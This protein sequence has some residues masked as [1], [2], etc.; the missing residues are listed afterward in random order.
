MKKK[1]LLVLLSALMILSA[2]S[3]QTGTAGNGTTAGQTTVAPTTETPTTE[4]PTEEWQDP[5]KPLTETTLNVAEHTSDVFRAL[6]RTYVKDN[7]FNIDFAC[8]GIHFAA[9]CEGDVKVQINSAK[10]TRF[11]IYVDGVR[12][13]LR[14]QV[15]SSN[16]GQYFTIAKDLPRG[17][18][19]FRL[20]SQTQFI[21]TYGSI[22]NVTVKGVFLDKPADRE[23]YLE[24]Y[25]DSILNGSNVLVAGGG[26]NASDA[27]QAFGFVTAEMMNADMAL[28][29]CS[30]I[31]LTTNS[32]SF[33]MKDLVNYAGARYS[34]F[35]TSK[36]EHLL[37]G[38]PE[39]DF[40][41]VPSAIIIEQGV[42]DGNNASTQ[43]FENAVKEMVDNLRSK[44]GADVPIVFPIGYS[45]P[46]AA[47]NTALPKIVEKLGG[48]SANLYICKLSDAASKTV[49][50]GGDG[51]H[52]G[53]E[54]TKKMATEL[55]EYLK[56]ILKK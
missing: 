2:V 14:L 50:P 25:G 17:E 43:A 51:T 28:I 37:P 26:I 22:G 52:P 48:E 27:T 46:N 6:G 47:Y 36:T 23:L 9:H 18:H 55:S 21:W 32:R 8:G 16:S 33:V 31:G 3:C 34:A 13:D 12:S 19:D 1:L 4:A 44:Y 49:V 53:V 42:N 40:S 41:R 11:T 39:W 15:T 24:F 30:S 35:S 56:T 7:L 38:I 10:D 45:R 54:S 29:G 5:T 20:I